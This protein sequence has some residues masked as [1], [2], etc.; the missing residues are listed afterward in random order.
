MA[1][2]FITIIGLGVTGNSLGLALRREPGDFE[3]VGHD[4]SND[5][6]LEAR[7]LKAVDRT[8]WNLHRAAEGSSLIVIA[9]PLTEVD[10]TLGHIAEDIAPNSLVLLV[11]P[12]LQPLV[13]S[14]QRFLP[15]HSRVVAGHSIRRVGA[16]EG[17]H[18][19][20]FEG[21]TF[22][23]ATT[24]STDPAAIELASDF[25][26]RIGATA[27]FTDPLEHDGVMALVDQLP[28]FV[29]TAL[30]TLS[31]SANGWRDSRRL[32]GAQYARATD[33]GANAQQLFRAFGENRE[34][35]TRRVQELQ[36][37]LDRLLALLA[38]EPTPETA[39]EPPPLLVELESAAKARADWENQSRA[40]KWDDPNVAAAQGGE[41]TGFLRQ[42]F[43]GNIGKK[44]TPNGN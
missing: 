42:L 33:L 17:A 19:N 10:D 38:T 16:V 7:R 2:P 5:A 31:S 27:H 12:L 21:A 25:I 15:N 11:G 34:N 39:D 13:E 44:K 22:S 29:G 9:L 30:V 28:Q 4:K 36:E 23:L 3:V 41:S 37:E 14:A 32:A 40:A 8:E 18:A 43:L 20:A 6:D 1:K 35:L 24:P 26:E